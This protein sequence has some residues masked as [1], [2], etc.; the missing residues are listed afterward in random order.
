[1]SA[2]KLPAVLARHACW[3]HSH[4]QLV[5]L[6]HCRS[7]GCAAAIRSCWALSTLWPV[8]SQSP[9][10]GPFSLLHDIA[11]S[12]ASLAV[13]MASGHAVGVRCIFDKTF[14]VTANFVFCEN[15]CVH[16][17]TLM[18]WIY[19]ML[20]IKK[21]VRTFSTEVSCPSASFPVDQVGI[22]TDYNKSILLKMKAVMAYVFCHPTI[23]K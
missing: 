16:N 5:N 10:K 2:L 22:G 7:T 6:M 11:V 15:M 1:M 17:L 12:D 13:G 21:S 23:Y 20:F 9:Q 8:S 14:A 3:L 4:S 18:H 19:I